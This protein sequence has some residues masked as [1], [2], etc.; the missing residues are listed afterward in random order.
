MAPQGLIVKRVTTPIL[1]AVS[2]GLFE[3]NTL[4]RG[5]ENAYQYAEFCIRSFEHILRSSRLSLGSEYGVRV[6]FKLLANKL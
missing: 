6:H 2:H 3:Y 4:N 1:N 5:T